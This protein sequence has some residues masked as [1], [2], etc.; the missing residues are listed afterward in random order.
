MILDVD[1]LAHTFLPNGHAK[2]CRAAYALAA[3]AAG[4]AATFFALRPALEPFKAA[5]TPKAWRQAV[6]SASF[7]LFVAFCLVL[8]SP[9]LYNS[10]TC[11]KR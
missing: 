9:L 4:C 5:M 8:P 10:L 1:S 11:K 7:F 3:N 6:R 2:R